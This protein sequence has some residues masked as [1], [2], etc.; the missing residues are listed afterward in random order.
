MH[1][2]QLRLR[3]LGPATAALL[4]AG[5]EA[6]A[7]APPTTDDYAMRFAQAE[8]LRRERATGNTPAPSR[9]QARPA[10]APIDSPPAP[11]PVESETPAPPPAE[12]AP[13]TPA[14]LAPPTAAATP[15]APAPPVAPAA[16]APTAL[17]AATGADLSLTGGLGLSDAP[18][19]L[20][21]Q[22]P[23]SGLRLFPRQ[24]PPIPPIPPVPPGP[25]PRNRQF[26]TALAPSARGFKISENQSPKPQDRV[27]GTFGYFADIN[28]AVNRQLGGAIQNM[29][30]YRELFGLEKTF[31]E[32]D[33]SLGLRMPLDTLVVRTPFRALGGTD[34]SVGNLTLFGKYVLWMDEP[35]N[36]LISTGLS[37]TTPTGPSRFAGS[38]VAPAIRDV[39]LQPFLGFVVNR[40]RFYAQGFTA[41][42]VPTDNRDVTLSYNDVGLGY[43]LIK[44]DDPDAFLRAFAPTFEVHV[45]TP[46]NHRG[47]PI[48]GDPFGTPDIVNLT[49][50]ANMLFGRRTALSVGFITPVTGPR[51]FD[52]EVLALLNIYF[53]RTARNPAVPQP[54]LFAGP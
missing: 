17:G 10:P 15:P 20:G 46:L 9:P 6:P 27:F 53:G 11:P 30:V 23:V 39:Q 33:A 8:R 41:I 7:Q 3:W 43:F 35:T 50:G 13:P 4:A 14:P 40:G 28:G 37:V 52:Y 49:Y 22:P 5:A 38:R 36:S 44:N 21:D 1:A 31:L 16:A 51:P 19:M 34:T 2:K 26:T 54:P 42:D 25:P 29:T 47:A 18:V 24:A 45:N 12:A 48:I 32:G